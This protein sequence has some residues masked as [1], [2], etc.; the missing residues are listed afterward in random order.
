M[1]KFVATHLKN[2]NLTSYLNLFERYYILK[3]PAF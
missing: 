1:S 3:N 2:K